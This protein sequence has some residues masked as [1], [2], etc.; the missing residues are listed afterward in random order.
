MRA[1]ELRDTL[2]TAIEGETYEGGK[3]AHFSVYRTAPQDGNF[4]FP[5]IALV[6]TPDGGRM[7]LWGGEAYEG[8][9]ITAELGF[10]YKEM[11]E[12]VNGAYLTGEDLTILYIRRFKAVYEGVEWG[13]PI[14]DE[15]VAFTP[16]YLEGE[17]DDLHGFTATINI[18]YK[19]E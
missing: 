6:A 9:T 13:V 17:A 11:A 7:E 8:V 5:T 12:L 1:L 14:Y 3:F 10:Q 2:A 15:S 18:I 16:R 4:V 19:A